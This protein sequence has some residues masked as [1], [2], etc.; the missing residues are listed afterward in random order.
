MK[1]Q[2]EAIRA[3]AKKALSDCADSKVLET[4]RVQY[5]GKKG[6]L[7]GILKQ[8]G[9]LSAEERP[10]MGQLA[11]QVRADIETALAD[12][13]KKLAEAMLA[14]KLEAETLDITL[15]GK[16]QKVGSKHPL[17]IVENRIILHGISRIPS[18]LQI[19]FCS[20]PRLLRYRYTSWKIRSRRSA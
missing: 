16:K 18:I 17:T 10:A 15:P 5:L 4:L 6:E 2:L 3:A 19:T 9:K 14:H 13:Q 7:T 11:N 20:V 12:K 8:M 1:E